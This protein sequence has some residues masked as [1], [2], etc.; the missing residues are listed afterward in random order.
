MS[1]HHGEAPKII[2]TIFKLAT[3]FLG[4]KLTREMAAKSSVKMLGV[5]AKVS[6]QSLL[7]HERSEGEHFTYMR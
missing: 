7:T 3:P 2:M 4:K 1:G 5:Q 6:K